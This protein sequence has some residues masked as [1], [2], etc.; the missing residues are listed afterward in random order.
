MP[1]HTMGTMAFRRQKVRDKVVSS[2]QL[3]LP[4]VAA[5]K[6]AGRCYQQSINQSF[7]EVNDD[8]IGL[9]VACGPVEVK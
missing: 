2:V 8:R 3:E 5:R 1:H 4:K 7:S 6:K 9:Q